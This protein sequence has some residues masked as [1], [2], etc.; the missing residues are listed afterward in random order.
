MICFRGHVFE[1]TPLVVRT[2][3]DSYKIDMIQHIIVVVVE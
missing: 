3:L 1:K 2:D